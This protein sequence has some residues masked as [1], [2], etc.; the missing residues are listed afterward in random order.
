MREKTESKIQNNKS[1]AL[2]RNL[3][4]IINHM[5]AIYNFM[6]YE[7]KMDFH[8]WTEVYGSWCDYTIL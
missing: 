5:Q 4:H 1:S 8:S 6:S 7:I 2:D 3:L